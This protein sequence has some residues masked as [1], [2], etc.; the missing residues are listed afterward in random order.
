MLKFL[1]VLVLQATHG[2]KKR[3]TLLVTADCIR[4]VDEQTKVS[5]SR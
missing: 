4:V 2:K 5:F 1:A 3:M